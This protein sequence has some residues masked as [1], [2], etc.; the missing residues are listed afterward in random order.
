MI[1]LPEAGMVHTAS[2]YSF[3]ETLSRLHASIAKRSIQ[4]LATVDHRDGAIR[5]GLTMQAAT[6]LIF[7][8]AKAGTPI[9]VAS[10]TSALDLPLKALVW[11]DGDG[12]VWISINSPHYLQ[13]RHNIPVELA[14][15][16]GGIAGLVAEVVGG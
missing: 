6:L 1:S 8:N 2:P 11:E 12:G 3:H 14:V 10:P 13:N 4:I 7:G 9:M 5:A 16:I 15:N